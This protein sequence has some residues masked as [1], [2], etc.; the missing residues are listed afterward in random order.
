MPVPVPSFSE[1]T[2][3]GGLA[4]PFGTV[5]AVEAPKTLPKAGAELLLPKRLLV[6]CEPKAGVAAGA[7]L[8]NKLVFELPPKAGVVFDAP[9]PNPEVGCEVE[10]K[11]EKGVD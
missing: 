4:V 5:A 11:P 8:A 10:P 6:G 7:A 3:N 1:K 9:K 2:E